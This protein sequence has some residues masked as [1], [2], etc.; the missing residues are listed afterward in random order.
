MVDNLENKIITTVT[1]VVDDDYEIDDDNVICFDISNHRIGIGTKNPTEAIT[2]SGG[3]VKADRGIFNQIHVGRDTIY[4]EDDEGTYSILDTCYAKLDLKH[5]DGWEGANNV[6]N[7]LSGNHYTLNDNHSELKDDFNELSNNY[8]NFLK[9][10]ITATSLILD[11]A[12]IANVEISN[13][14]IILDSDNI[15]E[16]NNGKFAV[17]R[18]YVDSLIE[19]LNAKKSVRYATHKHSTNSDFSAIYQMPNGTYNYFKHTEHHSYVGLIVLDSHEKIDISASDLR[20]NDRILI[21]NQSDK[22]LNG[23]YEIS[24]IGITLDIDNTTTDI[25][26]LLVRTKDFDENLDIHGAYVF[27][28]HGTSKNMDINHVLTLVPQVM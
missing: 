17:N 1:K 28:Q 18:A 9:G 5:F 10:N 8:N 20:E 23:V 2:I 13:G 21:K 7:D 27:V 26:Y 14:N 25:S 19:G 22:R 12:T 4:I 6:I 11:H 24:G 15:P 16:I 3:N